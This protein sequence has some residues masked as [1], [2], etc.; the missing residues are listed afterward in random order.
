MR[1]TRLDRLFCECFAHENVGDARVCVYTWRA[2]RP[3]I[4]ISIIVQLRNLT[5]SV[6][7]LGFLKGAC[8]HYFCENKRNSQIRV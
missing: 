7:M 6:F 2:S 1:H 3:D 4:L 8:V 5:R